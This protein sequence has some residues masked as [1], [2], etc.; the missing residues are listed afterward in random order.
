MDPLLIDWSVVYEQIP[1]LIVGSMVG[2]VFGYFVRGLKVVQSE[3]HE[4]LGE[5]RTYV[6]KCEELRTQ[7]ETTGDAKQA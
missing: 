5:I 4:M 3:T 1:G 2:A 6:K 7:K